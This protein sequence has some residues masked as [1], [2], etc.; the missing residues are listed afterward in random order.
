M[1]VNIIVIIAISHLKCDLKLRMH[2]K[3]CE[4]QLGITNFKDALHTL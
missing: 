1:E 2:F 3:H 4:L